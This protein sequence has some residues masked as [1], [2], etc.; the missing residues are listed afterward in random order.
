MADELVVRLTAVA[1][2][3]QQ[4]L[5]DPVRGVIAEATATGA[6]R[7]DISPGELAD[8]CPH[9]CP[10]LAGCRRRKHRLADVTTEIELVMSC[11]VRRV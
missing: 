6:I 4:Q 3:A 11:R 2:E 9:G 1:I 5:R 10:P 7:D 8:Y